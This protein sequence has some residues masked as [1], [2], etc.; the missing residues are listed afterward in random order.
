MPDGYY[1][2]GG[3][4]E[5]QRSVILP[6]GDVYFWCKDGVREPSQT[7]FYTAGGSVLFVQSQNLPCPRG[8]YCFG[9]VLYPCPSVQSAAAWLRTVTRTYTDLERETA[10]TACMAPQLC[11]NIRCMAGLDG[12]GDGDIP[13]SLCFEVA[14]KPAEDRFA[15]AR[16]GM[17]CEPEVT[18]GGGGVL[19]PCVY[20]ANS[21]ASVRC[22][23]S[24]PAQALREAVGLFLGSRLTRTSTLTTP[25]H[26]L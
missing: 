3:K 14:T 15:C 4:N 2:A 8:S 16:A 26:Y 25:A 12:H 21:A 19:L 23:C 10:I 24:S 5:L 22:L 6:C 9:G 13:H 1:S 18:C 17:G 7:G 11:E 20:Y